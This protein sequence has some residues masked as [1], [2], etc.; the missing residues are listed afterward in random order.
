MVSTRRARRWPQRDSYLITHAARGPRGV[1]PLR[2]TGCPQTAPGDGAISLRAAA[3]LLRSKAKYGTEG[4]SKKK[5]STQ[6]TNGFDLDLVGAEAPRHAVC[7]ARFR[8]TPGVC[9]AR[10]RHQHAAIA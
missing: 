4:S 6:Q 2:N 9:I 7:S 10:E 8:G 1:L 5:L 3:G